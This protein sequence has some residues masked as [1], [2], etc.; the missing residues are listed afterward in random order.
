[1]QSEHRASH[2]PAL[3]AAIAVWLY[4]GRGWTGASE[5]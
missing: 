1:M 5:Y 3:E 2:R 4:I